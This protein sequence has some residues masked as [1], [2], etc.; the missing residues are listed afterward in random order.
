MNK[1][2]LDILDD[3]AAGGPAHPAFAVVTHDTGD[4]VKNADQGVTKRDWFAAHSDSQLNMRTAIAL[5]DGA[6]VPL[7][8]IAAAKWWAVAEAK[9]RYLKAD[10]MMEVRK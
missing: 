10:A 7:G 6:T 4:I 1:T 2:N 3:D 9:H 5:M 8:A